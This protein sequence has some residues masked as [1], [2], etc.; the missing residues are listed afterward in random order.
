MRQRVPFTT[1]VGIPLTV[2]QY[3]FAGDDP[4][5]PNK[6][7][8]DALTCTTWGECGYGDLCSWNP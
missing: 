6:V 5:G 7:R 4:G 1:D 8:V 3:F 2:L